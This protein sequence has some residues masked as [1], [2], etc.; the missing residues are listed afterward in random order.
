MDVQTGQG[1]AAAC[2]C[3]QLIVN[4]PMAIANITEPT[5]MNALA[6]KHQQLDRAL[7]DVARE[8][9]HLMAQHGG[10]GGRGRDGE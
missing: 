2:G 5:L 4:S 7:G 6:E 3:T 8:G 9:V 1:I 10:L